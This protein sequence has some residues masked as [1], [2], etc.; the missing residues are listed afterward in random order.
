[1]TP[2]LEYERRTQGGRRGNFN[3]GQG[4]NRR[5]DL[6]LVFSTC[7]SPGRATIAALCITM[8]RRRLRGQ[9]SCLSPLLRAIILSAE[10]REQVPSLI[11]RAVEK[12]SGRRASQNLFHMKYPRVPDRRS[13]ATIAPRGN[14]LTL[15]QHRYPH[16]YPQ[17]ERPSFGYP[18]CHSVHNQHGDIFV[19]NRRWKRAT[20]A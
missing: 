14:R 20:S 2:D 7:R 11:A 12:S 4:S 15:F 3:I 6:F 5:P 19:N 8:D 16:F 13:A 1:M 18:G 17:V 9:L 10:T